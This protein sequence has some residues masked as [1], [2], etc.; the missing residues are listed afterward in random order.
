MACR[1]WRSFL[2]ERHSF[3]R[4]MV[5]TA[6]AA[7]LVAGLWFF[8]GGG[9]ESMCVKAIAEGKHDVLSRLA[10]KVVSKQMGG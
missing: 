6:M 9:A 8:L 5:S 3:T 7:L 4:Q 1:S 2:G 10:C